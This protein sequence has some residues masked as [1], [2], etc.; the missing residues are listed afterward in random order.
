[1]IYDSIIVTGSAQ[2]SGSLSVT[3]GITG[4]FQGTATTASYVLN[5][6]SASFATSA[7]AATTAS[8]V[9][10]AVSSSFAT[11]A[12][13]ATT[14]SYILNAASASYALT[15][16]FATTAV[17]SSF[18][19]AFTVAGTLTA[20]TLVVQTIT[21]S[22]DFVTGSTRFGSLLAN[23]H[24]FT[25]SVGMTGSLSVAGAT[26]LTGA[27]NPLQIKG[28]NASTQWTE[29]YYNTST[30]VGYI[31]NGS[32]ILTGATG[33]DFIF[34]SEGD[35]VVAT[36]G[37]NRRLTIASTGAATFS[38][39]VNASGII[40]ATSALADT[41]GS[42]AE[43]AYSEGVAY[44]LGYNRS[45]SAYLPVGINGS[46]VTISSGASATVAMTITSGSNVGIGTTSPSGKLT[47]AGAD[48]GTMQI[49]MQG[50]SAPTYYWEMGREAMSTGDFRINES[51]AGTV[52][53]KLTIK[54]ST[55]NVGI[56]TTSPSGNLHVSANSG[57]LT[58]DI[59]IVQGG[60]SP[61]GNFGF[62]CKA[63]NG[64]KIFYTDHL[65]YN[66][67]SNTAAG[68]F[69]IG[70][71]T[72]SA[73]LHV[74]GANATNRGQLSIQSNNA[75]NAARVTWYYD[76]TQQGEI[77]TTG[78]DFYALAVNNF[79]FY[80]GGSERMRITSGGQI[81]LGST[82]TYVGVGNDSGGVYM[83]TT[84]N[85]DGTRVLRIQVGNSTSALYSSLS[86]D[87]ANQYVRIST[88]NSERMRITSDGNVG[89]GTTS[90]TE[91]LHIY[92]TAGPEIRLEGAGHSWYI[93]AYNDNYNIYTPSGRQAVSYLNNG[94][95]RNYNNTTTW[96]QTSDVRVKEN[97]N[98]ISDAIGKILVLN[99]VIFDYKQEFADKNNWDNNKKINNVGFIAQE[100][101]TIFPKY[102]STNKYK[103]TETI[104]DDLKSIDT[105]HLVPYLVKAIQELQSQINELKNK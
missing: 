33:S 2:V 47:V 85:A 37:N 60:G 88:S 95:V 91:R 36:G 73:S 77:G 62:A 99:P 75:S 84:S 38:S 101:E 57:L 35:F 59:L 28:T 41:T 29:Y 24:A 82:A 22:V 90:P 31:G 89:I 69:G 48:D 20:T 43:V 71:T 3:G 6:V 5:A 100:F 66:V 105:G 65:T 53:N 51:Y 83:E 70:T 78:G 87:G 56:G 96:Q 34:R 18:A 19:N 55:G 13:N 32:G 74:Q 92:S 103:M 42:G 1:M 46:T 21:S 40:R 23:T 7:A 58:Q 81:N 93:R 16:S 63:N 52:T 61:S 15:S 98:T 12:A 64:D 80:A 39:F 45:T 102:I 50:T 25:G 44:F 67:Y 10:N 68:K 17:T 11:S 30:L 72:P 76:T 97:I 8:Y 79:L 104:I 27:T 54:G 26:T 9:L 94:D 14:S 49:R 4:S 86:I